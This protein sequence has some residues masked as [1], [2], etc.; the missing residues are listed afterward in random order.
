MRCISPFVSVHSQFTAMSKEV[1]GGLCSSVSVD[2]GR[3][4][5]VCIDHGA[6]E[7][8]LID[9]FVLKPF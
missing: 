8:A 2:R 7:K 9:C 5:C 6:A 1:A 4:H 3:F